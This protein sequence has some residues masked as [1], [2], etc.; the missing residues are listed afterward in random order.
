MLGRVC[1]GENAYRQLEKSR[2]FIIKGKY[3]KLRNC[4][5]LERVDVGYE[6]SGGMSYSQAV[7]F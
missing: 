6:F 7:G 3:M 4:F 2:K 5:L 1:E